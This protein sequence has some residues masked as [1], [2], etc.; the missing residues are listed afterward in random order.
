MM[1]DV[2]Y[3]DFGGASSSASMLTSA[4]TAVSGGSLEEVDPSTTSEE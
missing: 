4:L 1:L 2:D 3:E